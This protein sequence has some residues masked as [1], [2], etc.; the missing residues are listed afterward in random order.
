MVRERGSGCREDGKDA[1]EGRACRV[2][3]GVWAGAKGAGGL[4]CALELWDTQWGPG[5]RVGDLG[6]V[7]TC[8]GMSMGAG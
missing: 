1:G 3:W 2:S 8:R 6:H 4:E 5:R 7:K